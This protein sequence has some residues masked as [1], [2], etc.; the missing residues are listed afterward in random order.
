MCVSYMH[1]CK[2]YMYTAICSKLL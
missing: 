1:K 2:V